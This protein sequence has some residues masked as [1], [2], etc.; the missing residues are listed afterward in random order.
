MTDNSKKAKE[1]L[2]NMIQAE[3]PKVKPSDEVKMTKIWHGVANREADMGS[4]FAERDDREEIE[5][6]RTIFNTSGMG[7]Q[8][9]PKQSRWTRKGRTGPVDDVQMV[10]IPCKRKLFSSEEELRGNLNND[11]TAHKKGRIEFNDAKSFSL[12]EVGDCLMVPH[13][14]GSAAA[15][16]HVDRSQ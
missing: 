3:L 1:E 6:V 15:K 5:V 9:N 4:C 10:N 12:E 2:G 13:Y 8:G 7:N 16:R 11:I 14:L